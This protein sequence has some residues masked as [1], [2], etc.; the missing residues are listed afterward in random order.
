MRL[1][2]GMRRLLPTALVFVTLSALPV[3]AQ[4][5][6]EFYKG[7]TIN[8]AIGFSVGGGYDLYARHLARHMGKHIPATRPSCRRTWLGPAACARRISSTRRRRRTAP[9]SAPSPAPPAS[10]RSWKAA[11]P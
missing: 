3:R 7:K 6:E 5:V 4:S 9:R 1:E 10:I 8:L 11:R 2:F